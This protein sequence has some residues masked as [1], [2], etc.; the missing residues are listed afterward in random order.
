MR[1]VW[2]EDELTKLRELTMQGLKLREIA[3]L[4]NR[5]IP[6]VRAAS[7]V[8]GLAFIRAKAGKPFRALGEMPEDF[9]ELWE[10]MAR[11]KLALH[12]GRSPNT[13]ALWEKR[14]GLS[15]PSSWRSPEHAAGSP[16]AKAQ[17]KV[18]RIAAVPNRRSPVPIAVERVQRD[19]SYVGQAVDYLRQYGPVYRC[20]DKG[21]ADPA[22]TFWRRGC[23][24]LT[25]NEIIERARYNG[26]NPDAW[27]QVA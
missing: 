8:H 11:G 13:I 21:R 1:C 12:Y 4:L 27:R 3:P 24:V 17:T 22:G 15:R 25:G 10:T 7:K 16:K 6:S 19:M 20:T 18:A 23:S 14:C 2:S 26:W 5:S 9:P